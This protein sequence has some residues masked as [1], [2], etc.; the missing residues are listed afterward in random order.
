MP[1]PVLTAT[2]GEVFKRGFIAGPLIVLGHGLIEVTVLILLVAGLGDW[3]LW[4]ETRKVLGLAGGAILLLMGIQ[5]IWT[6]RSA[7]DQAMAI[8]SAKPSTLLQG[9]VL[10]G[11]LTTLSNPYFYVWWATIGLGYAAISLEHGPIGIVSFYTGHILSDLTWYAL[12]AAALASGRH[13]CPVWM[14]RLILRLCGLALLLLAVF[15]VR[16]GLQG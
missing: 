16:F 10:A 1:G 15:F 13:L 6:A 8:T 5:M 3:L 11:A 12:V 14:Y 7:A 4:P 9:P 2:V